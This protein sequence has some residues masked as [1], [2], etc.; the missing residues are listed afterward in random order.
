MSLHI[1]DYKRDTGHLRAAGHGAY[2]MLIMHYWAT[3]ALPDDD[4]QLAAIA[5]MADREWKEHKPIIRKFFG[6]GWTHKRIDDELAKANQK[7]ETAKANGRRGGRPK[8]EPNDNPEP[9]HPVISGLTQ[10]EPPGKASLTLTNKEEERKTDS[11]RIAIATAAD[12]EKFWEIYPRREGSNPK[13]PAAER[14]LRLVLAGVSSAAIIAG[15][16][17]YADECARL[18]TEGRF[19]TQAVVFLNQQRFADYNEKPTEAAKIIR[20]RHGQILGPE[21]GEKAAGKIFVLAET[22][23][24]DAWCGYVRDLGKPAPPRYFHEGW[25]FTT[26]WPPGCE[27]QTEAAE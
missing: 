22:P 17:R 7:Y 24:W 2:V 3:G 1:G 14:F 11:R 8:A 16:K 10:E 23:E 12:F 13:K 9:N 21:F 15:A 5:C 26:L 4:R 6:D 25:A 20:P 18:K 27:P 19:I